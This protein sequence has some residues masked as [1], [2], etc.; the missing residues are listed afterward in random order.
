M[1]SKR[2]EDNVMRERRI[3]IEKIILFLAP[4]FLMFAIWRY[5]QNSVE[6]QIA[7]DLV[8]SL[9]FLGVGILLQRKPC[10]YRSI[11][12]FL[13]IFAGIFLLVTFYTLTDSSSRLL[14]FETYVLLS[15]TITSGKEGWFWSFS[16]L[17]AAVAAYKIAP[18][19]LNLKDY[20]LI[21]LAI[22]ILIAGSLARWYEKTYETKIGF[23]RSSNDELERAVRERTESLSHAKAV[24]LKAQQKA[25]EASRAKSNFLANMSHEIRT[26]LNAVNGFIS[27]LESEESDPQKKKKMQTIREASEILTG[28]ISD[29][30]DLS[31]IESGSTQ[32]QMADFDPYVLFHGTVDLY[33]ATAA[34]KQIHMQVSCC[35]QVGCELWLRSDPLRIRQILG[36]LLS[37]AIKFTPEKGNIDLMACYEG[38]KLV[39][40]VKDDG[41]GIAPDNLETIFQP[42]QQLHRDPDRPE[43]GTGLGLAICKQLTNLLNGELHVTSKTGEGSTFT[44]SVPVTEVPMDDKQSADETVEVPE[45]LDAH[46]LI[47]EDI[48]AN[49]MFVEMVMDKYG[50]TYD[51]ADN[52]KAAVSLFISKHYDLILMDEN[53]PIM[54]GIEAAR[55]IRAYEQKHGKKPVPIIALTANAVQGDRER[56]IDAGMDDYLS[57]PI[58]PDRLM[59]LIAARLL[60]KS[61]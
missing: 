22:N 47:V 15:F 57:K 29:I 13:H 20:D 53:M 51:V 6:T 16:A 12:R 38:G 33:R 10:A 24:A 14:W 8:A 54:S 45:H 5:M 40:T 58:N 7:F 1:S 30:L 48:R 3:L 26:P 44:F 23:I 25:E 11:T 34:K 17:A 55:E 19:H 28:L 52:G 18:D 27:L 2:F 49:Q 32:L 9:A 43:A 37:N 21:V 4:L 39:F 46:V 31:K 61:V 50:I 60:R 36:N 59:Q 41:I 56:M 42:F 35:K